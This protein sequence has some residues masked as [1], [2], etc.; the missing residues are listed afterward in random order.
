MMRKKSP[1]IEVHVSLARMVGTLSEKGETVTFK[2]LLKDNPKRRE[3]MS[4]NKVMKTERS[5]TIVFEE[6][7]G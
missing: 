2:N 1:L 7:R 4:K 5:K 3:K 6:V